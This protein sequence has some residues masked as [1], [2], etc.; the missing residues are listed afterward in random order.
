MVG[1]KSP[2]LGRANGVNRNIRR[3]RVSTWCGGEGNMWIVLGIRALR[4]S[5]LAR[6][7]LCWYLGDIV[8]HPGKL[9]V[10]RN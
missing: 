4:S 8:T 9:E 2:Q 1:M 10:G 5:V 7:A 3:I 6:K